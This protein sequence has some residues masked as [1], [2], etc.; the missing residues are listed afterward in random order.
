MV[1]IEKI[2]AATGITSEIEI[3]PGDR[4]TVVVADDRAL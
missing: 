3:H 1:L 4:L 2:D